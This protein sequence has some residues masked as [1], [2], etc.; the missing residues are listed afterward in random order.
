MDVPGFEG[1]N[2]FL[3]AARKMESGKL[4]QGLARDTLQVVSTVIALSVSRTK[5]NGQN[6]FTKIPNGAGREWSIA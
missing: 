5:R 1:A 2:V 3:A 4:W 6:D